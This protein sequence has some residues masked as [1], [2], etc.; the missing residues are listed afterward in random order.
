M[1]KLMIVSLSA[2]NFPQLLLRPYVAVK[3]AFA[4]EEQSCVTLT[5]AHTTPLIGHRETEEEAPLI[6]AL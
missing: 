1:L 2:P 3:G 5:V 4:A 6:P